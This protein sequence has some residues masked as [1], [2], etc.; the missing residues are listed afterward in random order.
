MFKMGK[1]LYAYTPITGPNNIP[2][3]WPSLTKDCVRYQVSY[4]CVDRRE[5]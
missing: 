1:A 3:R 4:W 5:A 2:V